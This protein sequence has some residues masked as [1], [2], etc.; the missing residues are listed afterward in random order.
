MQQIFIASGAK[1][2]RPWNWTMCGGIGRGHVT[3]KW[4]AKDGIIKWK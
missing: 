1:N 3:I 4:N 2:K